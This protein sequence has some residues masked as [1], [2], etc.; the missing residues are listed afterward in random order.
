MPGNA[1]CHHL[2]V[3]LTVLTSRHAPAQEPA[4][5]PLPL[6]KIGFLSLVFKAWLL[7]SFTASIHSSLPSTHPPIHLPAHPSLRLPFHCYPPPH[8]SIHLFIQYLLSAC[9]VLD[10]VVGAGVNQVLQFHNIITLLISICKSCLLYL[11]NISK[12]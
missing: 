5:L 4:V 3:S 2:R 6:R 11:L 8:P 10:N 1:R 12:M 9:Q 7:S